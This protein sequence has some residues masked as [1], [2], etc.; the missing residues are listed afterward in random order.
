MQN[1]IQTQLASGFPALAG[2]AVSGTVAVRQ[3]LLNELLTEL[4]QKSGTAEPRPVG[5]P[6][7][8]HLAKFVKMASVRAEQGTVLIDF[9]IA[10]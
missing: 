3:E 7:F 2:T 4:L 8:A 9:K 1:W 6:D 5:G 10:V